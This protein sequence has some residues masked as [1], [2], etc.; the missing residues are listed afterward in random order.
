[1]RGCGRSLS[2]LFLGDTK[3]GP[4]NVWVSGVSLLL[5]RNPEQAALWG[6]GR[7]VQRTQL[8]TVFYETLA[9]ALTDTAV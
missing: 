9:L 8:H 7:A 2:D 5:P 3:E 4:Q 1:M 6:L